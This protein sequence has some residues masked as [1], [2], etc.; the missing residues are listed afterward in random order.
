MTETTIEPF[1][2]NAWYLGAWSDEVADGGHLARTIMNQPL[3]FFRGPDGK[4]AA[5]EDRC[6]H[7]GAP[8]THGNVVE[9][10]IECGYHGLIFDG[11]GKC[12]SIPG[13]D[14]IPPQT[15]VRSYPVVERQ[16][17]IW[18][19]MGDAARA[20]ESKIIDYPHHDDHAKWPHCKQWLPIKSNY[21]M[22]IDN[23]MDLTHLAYVH[24][25]TIGGNPQAHS[26]AELDAWETDYGAHYIRW[27]EDATPPPTYQKAVGFEGN[28]DRWWDFEFMAP[29]SVIQWNGAV[30]VGRGAR[31]NQDQPGFHLRLFHSATPETD[32]TFHYFWSAANGYQQDDPKATDVLYSE[33]APTFLED[34]E[35]M[36]VQQ[37]RIDLDPDRPLVTIPSDKALTHARSAIRRLIAEEQAELAQAAE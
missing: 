37:A 23:L 2:R 30:D 28:V 22:M 7:R 8:L 9:T 5:L 36:E 20:D 29:S 11:S 3:V 15:M 14:K 21:M 19:W 33:I 1:L 17:F 13:A 4:A 6:C 25:R 32:T 34:R 18:I 26:R 27:M 35:I 24:A 16:E 10:G 31:E 12:V